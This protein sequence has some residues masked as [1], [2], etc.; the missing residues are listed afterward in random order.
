MITVT[1]ATPHSTADL[2]LI[3][4]NRVYR[5]LYS[6]TGPVTKQDLAQTLSMSLPTLTQNLNELLALGLID[7]SEIADSTGGRK[8]RIISVVPAARTAVGVEISNGHIRLVALDLQVRELGFKVVRRTFRADEDYAA[9]L[10]RTIEDF[11]DEVGLSRD[12]FLGVGITIPGI[13]DSGQ[14]IITTAPTLGVRTLE[15]KSLIRHIPYPVHLVNDAN[16]GGFA[17]WW[18][19]TGV[20]HMAYLSLSRGVGGA[21]LINGVAYLGVNSRSGEF[22][23]MCIHPG[24]V[25]CSCGRRGCLE[26]YCSTARLSDDLGISLEQFFAGL[27]QGNGDYA[28]LWEA[29]LDD[30][31]IGVGNI[32]TTLDCGVVLGGKLSQF[33]SGH[34]DAIDSRLRRLDPNY[35]EAPYLSVCRYHDR[36]NGIGA[37]LYFVDRFIRQI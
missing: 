30:L 23:H 32:H 1:K 15:A 17:E 29:Y 9:E 6:A 26:A 34:F 4:R 3:N 19:R 21:I 27:A 12:R 28:R 8:P 36:S 33:L 2:R 14:E 25:P 10:A 5:Y 11:I 22:G 24:G 13:V 18:D 35:Q 7:N 31:A 16:A 37:A 20:E